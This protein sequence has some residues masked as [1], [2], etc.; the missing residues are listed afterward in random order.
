MNSVVLLIIGVAAMFCGYFLYSKFI[1]ERILK[2]DPNFVTPAYE[3]QDGM[4]YVPTNKFVL[5]GHHFTSVAGAAPIAGPAIAV[6]WG[7]G[8]AFLWVV[9]GTIFMAGVHDMCAIWASV[10]SQGKSLLTIT[11]SVLGIR[12]RTMLMIVMFLVLLMVNS[13]FGTIIARMMVSQPNSVLP[14]WGALAV[15]FVIGQC[16][17]RFKWNLP[18]V[19]IMGVVALYYLIW[20]GP[21]NP[22]RLPE[23]LMQ[24]TGFPEVGL[25]VIILFIYC[26]IA[27]L[28]PMWMLLQPRDYINGLQL[29]IGLGAL[30][31]SIL[32]VHPTVVAPMFNTDLPAGTPSIV[33]LLFV[34]IA[35]GAISGFHALVSMGTTSKQIQKESDVRFVGYLGAMGEGL[36]SLATILAVTA[37]FATLGDW[38]AMYSAFG[39]GGLDA[40]IA[41]GGQIM[42]N[43]IGLNHKVSET[44]LT[45]MV[46]LF[47]GTTMDTG[48][49]LQR[50]LLQEFGEAY[51]LPV[52]KNQWVATLGVVVIC[53]L[54][55]FGTGGTD[56]SGGMT[57]WPLFGT[58]NQLM[59]GLTLLIVSVMLLRKGVKSWYTLLPMAFLLFMTVLALLSQVKGFYNNQQWLLLVL[60]IIILVAALMVILECSSVLR[61]EWKGGQ[62]A[63]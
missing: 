23:G 8:P 36:L 24:A 5:W 37:G 61:R 7:W 6:I 47:A 29:F 53:M 51:K 30:Y 9:L 43:G 28:L 59:A 50:Y 35:C 33:P 60:D 4:D 10:R 32:I 63:S 11:N 52:L 2:L 48:V 15:A 22:I 17:Y 18:L 38:Q 44:M 46:A 57:I 12:G 27:S 19:S 21:S 14:V 62:K 20:I 54:L 25:W 41:G 31:L 49:R 55:V 58:T 39:K 26:A 40:F 42:E 56:G 1:A 45:V 3:L 16:I 13:A 34:T